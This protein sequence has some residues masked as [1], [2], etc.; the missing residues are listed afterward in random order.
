[1]QEKKEKTLN[2][3]QYAKHVGKSRT[4]IYNWIGSGKIPKEDIILVPKTEILIKVK[5]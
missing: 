1:M 4:A 5:D 2:I 3:S